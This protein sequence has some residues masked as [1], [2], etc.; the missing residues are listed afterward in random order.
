MLQAWY[1]TFFPIAE[2]T[3]GEFSL[4]IPRFI[5]AI[6]IL[7]IGSAVA[8]ILKSGFVSLLETMRLSSMIKKTPLEHFFA[9]AEFGHKVEE[10]LGSALY[11]LLMLV[12]LQAV[13]TTLGLAPFSNVIDRILS[14]IPNVFSAV[15]VLFLGVLLAGV[16]ES[17]VKGSIKSIDGKSSRLLGK[18]SSYLVMTIAVL[19]AV[20]ELGIASEFIMILFMGFVTTISL[21]AGL[22][23]GL[24]G[25]DLVAKV[26]DTWYEATMKEIEE[27]D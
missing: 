23:I 11:W 27:E 8:K 6:L 18:V 26:L 15:L 2:Q 17:L 10:V 7:V 14:Y 4:F 25:K 21:G 20:S 16:V 19:A 1:E 5:A 13:V 12:V 3:L 9:N 24:G 22:A